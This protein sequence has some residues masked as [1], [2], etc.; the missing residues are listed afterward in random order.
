MGEVRDRIEAKLTAAFQ[1]EALEVL[2]E[3]HLH[4]G[5]IGSRPDGETHFAVTIVSAAFAGLSRLDRQ[6]AVNVALA[7]D[8]AGRVHALRMKALAPGEAQP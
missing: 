7:E 1:P 2:D 6:R 5:H 3:S 8:L 4:A